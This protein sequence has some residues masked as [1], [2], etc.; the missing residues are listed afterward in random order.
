MKKVAAIVVTYNRKQL[1][2][3]CIE[4]LLNQSL[5]A[6]IIVVDNMSTDGTREMLEDFIAEKKIIYHSTGRNNLWRARWLSGKRIQSDICDLSLPNRSFWQGE[7]S[8]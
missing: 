8:L 7:T 3:S 2:K 1:L 6:D 5:K 4:S